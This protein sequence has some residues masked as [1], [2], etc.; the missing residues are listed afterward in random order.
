MPAEEPH[1]DSFSC[2]R[3]AIVT[4]ESDNGVDSVSGFRDWGA[5]L[6]ALRVERELQVDDAFTPLALEGPR[7]RADRGRETRARAAAPGPLDPGGLRAPARAVPRDADGDGGRGHRRRAPVAPRALLP[8]ALPGE[9]RRVRPAASARMGGG[10]AR[11][12]R[13]A[14]RESRERGRLRRPESLHARLQAALRHDAGPVSGRSSLDTKVCAARTRRAAGPGLASAALRTS[15]TD[16]DH[17]ADSP[18]LCLPC[19]SSLQLNR[20]WAEVWGPPPR[21]RRFS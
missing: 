19:R 20:S 16:R 11:A 21:L 1:R 8:G 5:M 3:T 17:G 15:R 14:A 4:V 6:V 2:D 12:H 18:G 10:P 9:P 13:R 7:A